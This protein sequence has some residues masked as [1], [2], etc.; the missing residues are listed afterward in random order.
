MAKR[1]DEKRGHKK[2]GRRNLRT[3]VGNLSLASEKTRGV[4]GVRKKAQGALLGGWFGG[5]LYNSLRERRGE[6]GFVGRRGVG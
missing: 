6:C 5:I 3:D 1:K 4:M 2:K